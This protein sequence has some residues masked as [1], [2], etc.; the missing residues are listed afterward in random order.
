MDQGAGRISL[1]EDVVERGRSGPFGFHRLEVL[2]E[3]VGLEQAVVS[4]RPQTG[5]GV[6][7]L[8]V[9]EVIHIGARVTG[10]VDGEVTT[11]GVADHQEGLAVVARRGHFAHHIRMLLYQ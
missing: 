9:G 11:L 7:G 5:I 6:R 2:D 3:V 8:R 1:A 4:L 10:R